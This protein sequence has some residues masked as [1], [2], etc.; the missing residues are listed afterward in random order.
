[1]IRI[2]KRIIPLFFITILILGCKGN[3]SLSQT[4]MNKNME[5]NTKSDTATFGTGCFWC[6]QAIFE[7]LKGVESAVAG[8]SGGTT[9]NPTYEQVCTGKTGYAEV[10]QVIYDP[11]IISYDELLKVFWKTH[12][13]TTLNRQGADVGT[14]YRSVIFYHNEDQKKKAEY[15]K[16]ELNKSG[17]WKDPI[18]TEI[19]PFTKFYKAENYHQDYFEKNPNQGYCAFVIAP[20]L[21]K[22]EKVFKDKLK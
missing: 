22:F 14:Q 13:P 6:S 8:Y 1:M 19:S 9:A 15:Y 16:D 2:I 11:K 5:T 21:E 12:N 20:K 4:T 7:R 17:A 10:C 18:V 3:K